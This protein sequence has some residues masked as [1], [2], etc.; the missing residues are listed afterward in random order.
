MCMRP[1]AVVS[2]LHAAP[3]LG[4]LAGAVL[5]IAALGLSSPVSAQERDEGRD[6]VP[7]GAF[8]VRPA[9]DG[10]SVVEPAPG[11]PGYGNSRDEGD[12]GSDEG[13]TRRWFFQSVESPSSA[14][15]AKSLYSDARKALD[16][17][18][19]AE[20]QKL[21]ERLIAEAPDSPLAGEARQHLG[22]LYLSIETGAAGEAS[23]PASRPSAIPNAAPREALP[24]SG[25][26]S[27]APPVDVDPPVPPEALERVRVTIAVDDQFLSEAGDRVFFSAGSVELGTRA[28][29]VI[30]SQARFLVRHPDLSAAVEGHAD[31]GAMSA[32]ETQRL[33][34]QRAAAV[35]DRLIAEGV[36]ARR[37]VA[38]GRGRADRVSDCPAPECLAQ[39]RRAITIL[40]DDL[41]SFGGR[42]VRRSQAADPDPRPGAQTQ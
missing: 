16:A 19:P 42:P 39:N 4:A 29:G 5:S 1:A 41:P 2:R 37:L 8:T 31:D 21:L 6:E 22:R 14:D 40:L 38:F 17:G 36:E 35:R 10:F 32:E 34:D 11:A 20:A 28:R 25:S 9:H 7:L 24:W 3:L 23:L 13:T 27:Q 33:S 18:R 15:L 12:E 30:Q 26:A